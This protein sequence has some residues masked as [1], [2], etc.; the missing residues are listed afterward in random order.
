MTGYKYRK[1][2][3]DRERGGRGVGQERSEKSEGSSIGEEKV[4]PDL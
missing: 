4:I 3:R 1:E 2:K